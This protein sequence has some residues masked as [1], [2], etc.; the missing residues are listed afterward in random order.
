MID[1]DEIGIVGSV[2]DVS[3]GKVHFR[4]FS[5]VIKLLK[6]DQMNQR[7]SEHLSKLIKQ[8]TKYSAAQSAEATS[9]AK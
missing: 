6:G 4:D 1:N 3:S 2:Y 7:L 5:P 8:E 9:E